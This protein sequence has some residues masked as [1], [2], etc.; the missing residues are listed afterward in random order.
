MMTGMDKMLLFNGILFLTNMLQ[1]RSHINHYWF[2]G[3]DKN[4]QTNLWPKWWIMKKNGFIHCEAE[5]QKVLK[6]V[7]SHVSY[8][9]LWMKRKQGSFWRLQSSL[10]S[11]LCFQQFVVGINLV[12]ICFFDAIEKKELQLGSTAILILSPVRVPE[13]MGKTQRSALH[14]L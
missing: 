5:I 6:V 7:E 9:S 11:V 12:L 4:P 8:R 13:C 2:L 14:P 1:W 3:K 10:F